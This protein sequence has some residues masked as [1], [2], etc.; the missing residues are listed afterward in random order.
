MHYIVVYHQPIYDIPKLPKPPLPKPQ[1]SEM[2]SFVHRSLTSHTISSPQRKHRTPPRRDTGNQGDPVNQSPQ[3]LALSLTVTA[4]FSP[5]YNRTS[6]TTNPDGFLWRDTSSKTCILHFVSYPTG[7]TTTIGTYQSQPI[8]PGIGP[9]YV[10]KPSNVLG[11][12]RRL[13][14]DRCLE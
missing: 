5:L 13:V 10:I 6:H 2:P 11:E 4:I 1:P 9:W 8:P 7:T 12:E 14:I 3:T